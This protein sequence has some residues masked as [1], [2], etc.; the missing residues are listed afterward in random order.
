MDAA[1]PCLHSPTAPAPS[2]PEKVREGMSQTGRWCSRHFR[3]SLSAELSQHRPRPLRQ[4]ATPGTRLCKELGKGRRGGEGLLQPL[5]APGGGGEDLG[6][7]SHVS[8]LLPL[9]CE[10]MT[11]THTL[12]SVT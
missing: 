2:A 5:N 7:V 9:A 10:A 3:A 1:H 6:K 4:W 11:R 8:C 12:L